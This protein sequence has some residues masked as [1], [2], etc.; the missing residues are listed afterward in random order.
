[1]FKGTSTVSW[2]TCN[3]HRCLL[4]AAHPS[5]E[6]RPGSRFQSCSIA[7][8]FEGDTCQVIDEASFGNISIMATVQIQAAAPSNMPQHMPTAPGL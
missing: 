8:C 7:W 6:V 2:S 5:L 4:Q 3:P 1:M